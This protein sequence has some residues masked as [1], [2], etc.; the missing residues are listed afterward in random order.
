MKLLDNPF[1]ILKCMPESTKSTIHEQAEEKSF[2]LDENI[3]KN[4]ESILINPKKRLEAEISWFPGF[5][6]ATV[7]ERI[8]SVI[9]DPQKYV[10][11]LIIYKTKNYL[12]EANLLTFGLESAKNISEWSKDDIRLAASFLCTFCENISIEDSVNKIVL[13]REKSKFPTNVLEEDAALY[14]DEQ[15]EYYEKTLYDF[16]QKI[17]SDSVIEILTKMVKESTRSGSCRCKWYLLENII[18]KYEIDLS[19]FIDEEK[20]LILK[21]IEIIKDYIVSK[22]ENNLDE[23]YYKLEK[24]LD[25]WKSVVYPIMVIKTSRG[26]NDDNSENLFYTIRRLML[27]AANDYGNYHFSLRLTKLCKN[28]FAELRS[29]QERMEE[30]DQALSELVQQADFEAMENKKFMEL[31]CVFGSVFKT[32]VK[33]DE[34]SITI[35]GKDVYKFED[36]EKFKWGRTV[37]NAILD[38]FNMTIEFVTK[39]RKAPVKLT[40]DSEIVFERLKEILWR[41][42]GILILR[43]YLNELK[44]GKT[45]SIGSTTI[46]D[47][48]IE[49]KEDAF[50]FSSIKMFAWKDIKYSLINGSILEIKGPDSYQISLDLNKEYNVFAFYVLLNRFSKD[51]NGIRLTSVDE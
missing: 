30:D 33:T 35:N 39:N 34:K 28:I 48:G 16:F 13:S 38:T 19:D 22:K 1:Y 25:Y 36:I 3:C 21:D 17:D 18:A 7:S 40:L 47:Y 11:D 27:T 10:S 20:T 43:K 45:I 37:D 42:A 8:K 14:I 23:M 51:G 29:I 26:L 5:E 50:I 49:L 41:G 9:T 6:L 32:S 44:K 31:S 2:D 4:A 46:Y 15:K 24:D 12:A